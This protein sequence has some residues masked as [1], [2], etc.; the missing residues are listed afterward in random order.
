MGVSFLHMEKAQERAKEIAEYSE[1]S[2]NWY[3]PGETTVPGDLAEHVM[4]NGS[5]R[6]VFCWTHVPDKDH[7]VRRHLSISVRGEG[8]YPLPPICWTL[9]HYF[10]F[11]G[12]EVGAGGLVK[13]PA[14][15]WAFLADEDEGCIV[16]QEVV[17][18]Q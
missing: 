17:K 3:K 18:T 11:T 12:A 13:D 1:K 7:E 16:L 4:L 5:V 9:A 10:G 15:S 2:E 6:A 14:R 8:R